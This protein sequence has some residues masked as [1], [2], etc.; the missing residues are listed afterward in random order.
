MRIH[1]LIIMLFTS[2]LLQAQN[3]TLP[4]WPEGVPGI[5]EPPALK[6]KVEMENGYFRRIRQVT[7]PLVEVYLPENPNASSSAVIVCPGGG[8]EFLS[9]QFEGVKVAQWLNSL[10]IAAI[11]LKSRLPE[12]Q[13]FANSSHAPLED[14]HKAISMVRVRSAEWK[15]DPDKV[16]IAGFSAGG[17]L[18]AS[19]ST[20]YS[21]EQEKPNFSILIYPVI[22]MDASFTHMGSRQALIGSDPSSEMVRKFSNE[23][24]VNQSTPHAFLVHTT[25]DGAVPYANSVRYFEALTQAGI[26]G[27]ELHLFPHGGHGYNLADEEKGTVRS[28]P[29]LC[30]KWLRTSKWIE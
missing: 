18:A 23:L 3:F 12:D 6:E 25:D 4:L 8:Y 27:S 26:E 1:C 17:H 28:W 22:T 14:V 15:I 21:N 9:W 5:I 2:P 24:Q 16:G 13:L 20:Q 10:G 30:E 29:L 11:V 7:H 19:A